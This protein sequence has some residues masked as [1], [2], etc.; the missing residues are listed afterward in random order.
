MSRIPKGSEITSSYITTSRSLN[1]RRQELE[2]RYF[3][4]CACPECSVGTTLGLPDPPESLLKAFPTP[5]AL[6]QFEHEGKID[7][8]I[9]NQAAN[10][11]AAGNVIRFVLAKTRPYKAVLPPY[12]EPWVALRLLYPQCCF[13][14]GRN[15]QALAT[16]FSVYLDIIPRLFPCSWHP[17][18]FIITLPMI[19]VLESFTRA[20]AAHGTE[21]EKYDLDYAIVM[22]YLIVEVLETVDK[23][24]GGE[25]RFA[26]MTK[27]AMKDM[28]KKLRE[29]S[30]GTM[31]PGKHATVV[32]P[33]AWEM[34]KQKMR[35][36][37]DDFQED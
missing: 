1:Q 28:R 6:F 20:D 4:D 15:V 3:F 21:L 18:R 26:R 22:E 34:Q 14:E 23:A 24:Y 10:L 12:R 31:G 2:A 17:S 27:R 33:K 30:Q 35:K 37:A 13:A 29:R 19:D 32:S 9:V 11:K 7:E 36:I 8:R 5:R 25:S 16:S